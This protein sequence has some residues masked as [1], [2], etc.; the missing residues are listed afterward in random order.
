MNVELD[1]KNATQDQSDKFNELV[2]AA[3][4]GEWD[5]YE[6]LLA[7]EVVKAAITQGIIKIDLDDLRN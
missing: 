1:L 7:E 5:T 6:K 3:I 4:S 2:V